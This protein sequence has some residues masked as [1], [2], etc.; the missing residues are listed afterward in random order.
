MDGAMSIVGV[1]TLA[2]QVSSTL[3]KYTKD[4]KNAPTTIKSLCE[5]VESLRAAVTQVKALLDEPNAKKLRDPEGLEQ[6]LNKSRS[7][8]QSLHDKLETKWLQKMKRKCRFK[9]LKWP[10][11]REDVETRIE[12]LRKH[13]HAISQTLQVEH[14]GVTL[15]N[16]QILSSMNDRSIL[17]TLPIASGAL[18]SSQ[19]EENNPTCQP[20]TRVK[21]LGDIRQWANDPSAKSLFWLNGM[22]GTGKS[23]ISRTIC[24]DF[25]KSNQLGAS[26]FFKR[27]EGDRGNLSRFVTTIASQL[28]QK[29]GETAKHI[30]LAIDDD[31]HISTKAIREQFEKLILEPLKK[32]FLEAKK[33][34][35]LVL[36]LDALDEC[37]RYEDIKLIITLFS[38]CARHPE[39]K[40]RLKCLITSRPELPIRLGFN[41]AKGTFQDL[42]LHDIPHKLIEQDITTFLKHELTRIQTEFNRSVATGRQLSSSW[43]GT[44]NIKA[45]VKKAVPLFIYA[46]TMCRFLNDRRLGDPG[47]LLEQILS[48]KANDQAS[49]LE[50][51]YMPVL[52]NLIKGLTGKRKE[53]VIKMF[54]AIV[55]PVVILATPLTIDALS[56]L[57]NISKAKIGSQLDM[58]HSVLDVPAVDE[59]PVRLFHLSFRDFLID[60]EKKETIPFYVDENETHRSLAENCL[61][62]MDKHF[63][64]DIC[65]LSL[66]GTKVSEIESRIIQSCI[67]SAL[68]YACLY[69]VSHMQAGKIVLDDKSNVLS[70]LQEHL[71]HWLEVMSL[72]GRAE[73]ILTILRSLQPLLQPKEICGL[74]VFLQDAIRVVRTNL[75]TITHT[76]LQIYSSV[77]AF[78]PK[79]SPVRRVF[80]ERIP[81]WI[82]LKPDTNNN[83]DQCEQFLEGHTANVG[84]VAFSLDG[85]LVASASNDATVR[86]WR[87]DDGTC[88][89]ILKGHTAPVM[90][91]AFSPDSKLV[92]SASD[93]MT[94]RLWR[95]YDGTCVEELKGHTDAVIS[96]AFSPD[97]KLVASTSLDSTVRLWQKDNGIL[98]DE[99][100]GHIATVRSV[101][102]SPDSKLVASASNDMTVRL[103]RSDDGTCE[104][105]LKG[106]T[107]AVKS[108][109]FSPDGRLVASASWDSSV[110]LWRSN[111]GTCVQEL[112]GHTSA[113]MSVAFS[114][115]SRLV[116]STSLD[117]TIRLWQS[118]NGICVQE[119]KG[120]TAPVM[121]VAFSPDSKLVASTSLDSTVRLW[122]SDDGTCIQEL[123]GHTAAVV[124]VAFSPDSELVASTSLDSMV[125]LWRS[126]GDTSVQE[127][128]G[129][130]AAVLFMTFSPDG[131]LVASISKDKTVRLWRK[132]DGTCVRELKGHTTVVVSLAFSPDSKLLATTSQ[133]SNF[134]VWR[135]DD[136]TCVQELKGNTN[137]VKSVA[138]SP[139]GRLVA[140]ASDDMTVHLWPKDD[141][142]HV[143]RLKG[144]TDEINSVSFSPDG[145]LVASGS[146]DKTIRLW[147]SGDGTFIQELR[148]H[149][150]AV[151]LITFS[152]DGKLVASTSLDS[153]VRLWRSDDGVCVHELQGHTAPVLS[154]AFSSDSKFVAST[155]DDMTVRL[156]RSDDGT[157]EQELKGHTDAVKLVTFSPDGKLVASASSDL[158][159]RLWRSDDGALMDTFPDIVTQ[160]L[161]FDSQT[162][163]I[164]TDNYTLVVNNQSSIDQA[165]LHP[166]MERSGVIRISSDRCWITWDDVPILWIPVSFRG[167]RFLIH[168]STVIIGSQTGRVT[169]MRFENPEFRRL[170]MQRVLPQH[171]T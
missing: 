104:Q 124:S 92:A 96:V 24:N 95:T 111:D 110:R 97:S 123:K 58:L 13:R 4:V 35:S 132:D 158:T 64:E 17:V 149:T 68:E 107:D 134:R 43:P 112:D 94:V 14:I 78:T 90:S 100:Q 141:S 15:E 1:V 42:V 48:F 28:A 120:H 146:N 89:K 169:I 170:D 163:F 41:D 128:T 51:T 84:I 145:T 82:S 109:T 130:T 142:T 11:K 44:Q 103:W 129:H 93:D 105:E 85:R 144:H 138:F 8:L 160:T 7:E 122:Q 19:D 156:W 136:G 98:V 52:G 152:P 46:A 151:T 38:S 39:L 65:Q 31:M 21:I 166:P 40:L 116:A 22:A 29:Y 49:K 87:S 71:L 126:D 76:P 32:T 125:G 153:A 70:F 45:L 91:I 139:D 34:V 117:S 63:R 119:L 135:S 140:S 114:P 118:D 16:N 23:T 66:P 20:G 113:V 33:I 102:F 164:V 55:G 53:D 57:L 77:L 143:Q 150:S 36:V 3:W 75:A 30:K 61:R 157:C 59:L 67:P 6:S 81:T 133:D 5:E 83:W 18:F 155:S 26:F 159:V 60:T 10:F 127:L 62:V 168:E 121:S 167:H 162:A 106:H 69:W 147:Q 99:L 27:G 74:R 72:I 2:A 88:V 165:S 47:D 12:E 54:R 148:G 137:T 101:T 56:E 73:E 115:D 79:N 154:I 131:R 161:K 108:V 86:L 80:E 37:D 171:D 50:E 9:S 25:A